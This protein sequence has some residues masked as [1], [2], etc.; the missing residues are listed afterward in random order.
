MQENKKINFIISF[1]IFYIIGFNI[2]ALM[3]ANMEFFC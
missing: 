3:T 1:I 2:Y